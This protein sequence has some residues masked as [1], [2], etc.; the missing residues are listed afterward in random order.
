[1]YG[2]RRLVE[3]RDIARKESGRELVDAPPLEPSK[4]GY[5]GRKATG[6]KWDEMLGISGEDS[7]GSKPKWTKWGEMLR[8][9][10]QK[11]LARKNA[12]D[13]F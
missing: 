7:V 5:I 10:D 12:P 11:A 13:L 6:A 3:Q 8:M 9:N 4:A 1:M 2:L